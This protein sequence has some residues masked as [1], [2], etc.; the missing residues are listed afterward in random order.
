MK[1]LVYFYCLEALLFKSFVYLLFFN[2]VQNQ[3]NIGKGKEPVNM[4]SL[5]IISLSQN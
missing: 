4:W 3:L 1:N 5:K 2:S